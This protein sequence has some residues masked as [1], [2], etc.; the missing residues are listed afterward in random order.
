MNSERTAKTRQN[1]FRMFELLGIK[2]K[3]IPSED[4]NDNLDRSRFFAVDP[5]GLLLRG[6]KAN[7]GPNPG[8]WAQGSG[9]NH[10]ANGKRIRASY[11]SRTAPSVQVCVFEGRRGELFDQ[12]YECYEIDLDEASPDE[13]P[14]GH[15]GEVIRNGLTGRKTDPNKVAKMITKYEKSITPRSPA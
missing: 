4:L 11:R 2:H 6:I 3:L 8:Q 9:A 14:L 13:D 15:A 12:Y 1:A 5:D 7:I 10:N